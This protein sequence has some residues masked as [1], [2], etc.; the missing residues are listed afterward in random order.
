MVEPNDMLEDEVDDLRHQLKHY[1]EEKER[2]RAIIGKIGG[3][4]KF[5]TRLVNVLFVAAV[6]VLVIISVIAG[7]KWRMLMIEIATVVLSLK[8]IYLIHNQTKVNHFEFWMLSSIEWRINE[9]TTGVRGISERLEDK[10]TLGVGVA[11][12]LEQ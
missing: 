6:C 4:P 5:Q 7:E 12:Q 8:I 3:V 9:L 2:V 11:P 1:Q 10:G